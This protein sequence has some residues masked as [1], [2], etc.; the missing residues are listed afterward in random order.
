MSLFPAGQK[1]IEMFRDSGLPPAK[2]EALLREL[3]AIFTIRESEP[4]PV[5][6][7]DGGSLDLGPSRRKAISALVARLAGENDYVRAFRAD[8]LHG[9]LLEHAQVEAWIKR[10][11]KR[12]G[13]ATHWL[14]FPVPAGHK[15]KS[16]PAG[17]YLAPPLTISTLTS[18]GSY[19]LADEVVLY[20]VPEDARVRRECTARHGVLWELLCL[21][22]RLAA[23]YQWQEHQATVFVLAGIVPDI[24][25][26][27]WR[28][29]YAN[30]P[31]L[32]RIVLDM[33]PFLSAEQLGETYR[34]IQ[35][36]AKRVGSSKPK[37]SRPISEQ[38]LQI[39]RFWGSRDRDESM[40]ESLREWNARCT[41]A[42]REW[43]PTE[44]GGPFPRA[45]R[46]KTTAQQFRT[47]C[48]RVEWRLLHRIYAPPP[49]SS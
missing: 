49:S 30:L 10:Q 19:G 31:G 43:K 27:R 5:R 2:V 47:L 20:S 1:F 48:N 46:H 40:K 16:G 7:Y 38:W 4:E 17:P 36:G 39:A 34:Q 6:E 45:W 23:G 21:A 18:L 13:P 37:R 32:S 11:A 12:D 26:V 22:R 14:R 28:V 41:S 15:L 44:E 24:D 29:I 25:A 8:V 33:H 3:E 9:E 42:A 35:Q